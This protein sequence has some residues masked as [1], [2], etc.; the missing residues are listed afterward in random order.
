VNVTFPRDSAPEIERECL[1]CRRPTS[2][3]RYWRPCY[4]YCPP[5]W[6][7]Y[8]ERR[9]RLEA[10]LRARYPDLALTGL[11]KRCYRPLSR[12]YAWEGLGAVE[13]ASD[14]DLLA[15][16]EIGPKMVAVFRAA[17]PRVSGDPDWCEHAAMVALAL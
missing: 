1:R 6:D 7:A 2:H 5:C 15:I 14:A 3:P 12:Q 17:Y 9:E 10:D 16:E 11:G 8:R 13:V 4:W